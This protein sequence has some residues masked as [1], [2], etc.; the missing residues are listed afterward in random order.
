[1]KKSLPPRGISQTARINSAGYLPVFLINKPYYQRKTDVI[2]L[3][4]SVINTPVD[5]RMT[6]LL[7]TPRVLFHSGNWI[8]M[9]NSE[10]INLLLVIL[11]TH[12]ICQFISPMLRTDASPLLTEY[13]A[14]QSLYPFLE[15]LEKVN[16]LLKWRD[17]QVKQEQMEGHRALYTRTIS[18]TRM[19]N[20]REKKKWP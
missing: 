14:T 4:A 16:D 17:M 10:E 11:W 20:T 3:N 19:H 7:H 2:I 1:M 9:S 15:F 13:L 12:F 5:K 18:E 8:I 6:L